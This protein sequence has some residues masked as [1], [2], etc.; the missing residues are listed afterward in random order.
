MAEPALAPPNPDRRIKMAECMRI[1]GKSIRVMQQMAESGEIP[2]AVKIRGE[3]TFHEASVRAWMADLERQQCQNQKRAAG[4]E[5][6]R[7]T[8]TG[9][10][11]PSGAARKSAVRS[12]DGAYERM[13]SKLGAP[14]LRKTSRG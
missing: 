12:V 8:P 10:M 1:V 5:R 4:A 13:M 7:P 3:W 6:P 11:A 9:V 2:S 14:A